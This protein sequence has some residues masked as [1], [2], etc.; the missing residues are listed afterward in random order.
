MT[1]RGPWTSGKCVGPKD[2]DTFGGER[3]AKPATD[4]TAIGP[5]CSGCFSRFKVAAKDPST[6]FGLLRQ[7]CA[8]CGTVR[9]MHRKSEACPQFV[10]PEIMQ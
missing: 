8:K 2:P 9:V 3:C 5:L 6:V 1:K 10:E 4:V 7:K